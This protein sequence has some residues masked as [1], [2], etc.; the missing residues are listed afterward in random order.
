MTREMHNRFL[1]NADEATLFDSICRTR[2]GRKPEVETGTDGTT[3]SRSLGDSF[4]AVIRSRF[5][6]NGFVRAN[7]KAAAGIAKC[8]EDSI[9]G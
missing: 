8:I 3:K 1:S 7:E 9:F 2:F 4:N 6:V 5:R